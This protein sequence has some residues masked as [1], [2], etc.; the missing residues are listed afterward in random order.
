[1]TTDFAS[2]P[3]NLREGLHRAAL[4]A[5]QRGIGIFDGR[6][7][8]VERRSYAELYR[9]ASESGRRFASLGVG[10]DEPVLVALPTSWEWMEAWFGLLMRGAWPVASC[11][12]RS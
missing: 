12:R 10:R 2:L 3:T 1:V 5:P 6:G 4:D 8:S 7:R 11:P 9:L